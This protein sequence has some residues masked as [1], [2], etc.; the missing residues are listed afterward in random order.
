M[1]KLHIIAKMEDEVLRIVK[2]I[3]ETRC[4]VLITSSIQNADL[5]EVLN[6]G[7]D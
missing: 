1:N 7:F 5:F 2:R 4:P 3:I 6:D